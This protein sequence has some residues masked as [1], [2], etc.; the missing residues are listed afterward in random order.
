MPGLLVI[1]MESLET[2]PG[3]LNRYVHDLTRALAGTGRPVPTI[4]VGRGPRAAD[5]WQH[6]AA[7]VGAPL[8]TRLR[9]VRAEAGRVC[10]DP[11]TTVLDV[12]FALY[13]AAVL[14]GRR[15][16]G[17][18]VH[19]HGPW[20]DESRAEGGRALSIALKRAVERYVFRRA[21]RFVTL[22]ESFRSL[23]VE[24]YAVPADRVEVLAP[25]VDLER[26]RPGAGRGPGPGL[27]LLTVR[28]LARRMGLDVL[29]QAFARLRVPATLDVAGD[30]EERAALEQLARELGVADRVRFLGRV[31]EPDL[32]GLYADADLTV[33]PS[34]EL[35]G[36]GLVVLESLACG[37][38]VV[39][40][41][42]G[43]MAEVLPALQPDLLVP[44]GDV[45]ALAA[46]LEAVA[47][48]AAPAPDEAACRAFA[49]RYSWPRAA[50]ATLA[51]VEQVAFAR[52]LRV[53]Y[54]V[55]SAQPAGG[56]LALLR[57]LEGMTGVTPHVL[58][59][60]DGPLVALLERQGISYEVLP[61]G[62]AA[63][64]SRDALGVGAGLQAAG[65]VLKVARR[66]RELR[67]DVVHTNSLKAALYGGPAARLAG[68]PVVWHVRDRIDADN[69]PAPV[70]TAVR[71]AARLLPHA[72]I[73]NSRTTLATLR[74]PDGAD[75]TVVPS[76]VSGVSP[77]TTRPPGPLRLGALG[78][79]A[80]WKGQHVALEAFARAFPDGPERLRVIGAPLFG[81]QAYAD[82]L[83]ALA[84]RLGVTE[85]VEFVGHVTDVAGQLREL[86]VLVHSSVVPEP[87]GNVVVEGLA[88]GLAVVASDAGGPREVV[89]DG[90][91]GLLT[92]M[93]DVDALAAALRRLA[94]D[95]PLRARLGAAAVT[96]AAGYGPAAAASQVSAVYRRVL[97]RAGGRED[98]TG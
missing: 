12:H 84:A 51:L 38:P 44:P 9:A 18:V 48:G 26:F 96:T 57:L 75:T 41:A 76:P 49:E 46:R 72:V 90:V 82:R 50:Q 64:T 45:D 16:R 62:S 97:G 8:V 78:R 24:R 15:Y 98:G 1:G 56:E 10:P 37:T 14:A 93:G 69:Y 67:A 20:A 63:R 74:L 81:E 13:G 87:F 53:V 4:F 77:A 70:V 94:D 30:G 21:D 83:R 61:L 7:P 79:L 55:H 92:P 25:G 5:G 34:L 73:A 91:D 54:L 85:R 40:S 43:G 31:P 27:R 89:T 29:L 86:D 23:L 59:A 65:Y 39:A 42:T 68:V 33:V 71:R 88:A 3:G 28:R 6:D 11:G 2:L 47:T 52:P 58:L 66:L 19:F 36:F 17:V 22:S 60:E 95:P 35:E 80:E 32:P